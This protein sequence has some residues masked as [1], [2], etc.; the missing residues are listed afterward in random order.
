MTSER[1]LRTFIAQVL[2]ETLAL[3]YWSL[4][5]PESFRLA[6]VESRI[7]L[8]R[9]RW[10]GLVLVIVVPWL[11]SLVLFGPARHFYLLTL[12]PA[13]NRDLARVALAVAALLCLVGSV[14]EGVA[15]GVAGGIV[16]VGY[17]TRFG[18][19]TFPLDLVLLLGAAFGMAYRTRR[20]APGTWWD[21][22]R[23]ALRGGVIFAMIFGLEEAGHL[24]LRETGLLFVDREVNGNLL[25]ASIAAMQ[26]FGSVAW[27]AGV[28]FALPFIILYLGLL[29]YPL[30]ALWMAVLYGQARLT[31][32]PLSNLNP[33]QYD[34]LIKFPLPFAPQIMAMV[35]NQ[36]DNP[37]ML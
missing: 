20:G 9:A 13:G 36:T 30:E 27:Q 25:P 17:G 32:Y 18:V 37:P 28:Y 6:L 14:T 4:L 31:S 35:N 15:F 33:A 8:S 3:L 22:L 1:T 11:W 21:G 34:R 10:E 7:R 23:E 5:Q 29:W 12:A 16:A 19:L 26:R 2:R 24:F